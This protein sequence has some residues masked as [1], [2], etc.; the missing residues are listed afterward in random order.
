MEDNQ[1]PA[2]G[3]VIGADRAGS[4]TI[5]PAL[6]EG[7]ASPGRIK[8]VIFDLGNVLIDF[9]HMI[10]VQ[11]LFQQGSS[12][13]K[14]PGF[15]DKSP[16]GIFN[17]FFDSEL[18]E[19]FEEGRLSGPQFFSRVKEMLSLK[20][21]YDEFLPIWNE[22]FF[23]SEKNLSVYNLAV[24]L[25]K[26]YKLAILSNIN[27]LHFEYI[28]RAFPIFNAF[29]IMASFEMG[30][31]KPQ[32]RIYHRALEILGVSPDSCFYADDR[33]ELVESAK[34]LGIRGFVFKDVQQ[35]TEDLLSSGIS[36][37]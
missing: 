33:P 1:D 27:I 7:A 5:G 10:A 14:G 17:L 2:M 30:L 20:L 21:D 29:Q 4:Q 26:H 35:L 23:F 3:R 24:S 15:M 18:T 22:I 9:D 34:G 32:S 12:P 11:K 19:L 8:A 16:D 28:K 25:G 31:R 37:K 6:S 36:I 13:S